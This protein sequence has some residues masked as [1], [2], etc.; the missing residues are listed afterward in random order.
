VLLGC[1]WVVLTIES[2]EMVMF[3]FDVAQEGDGDWKRCQVNG[4]VSA[5]AIWWGRACEND[6]QRNQVL[7]VTSCT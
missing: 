1:Q 2:R 7:D 6:A 5:P 3:V 4:E